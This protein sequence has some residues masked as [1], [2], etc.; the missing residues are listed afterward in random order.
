VYGWAAVLTHA[1]TDD[2]FA[3]AL[4]FLLGAVLGHFFSHA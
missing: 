1:G 3:A 4:I 2:P